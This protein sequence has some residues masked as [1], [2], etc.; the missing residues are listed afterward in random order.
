MSNNNSNVFHCFQISGRLPRSRKTPS[1][2]ASTL[3]PTRMLPESRSGLGIK[4]KLSLKTRQ[5]QMPTATDSISPSMLNC[6]TV[7]CPSTRMR[8]KNG[9]STSKHIMNTAVWCAPQAMPIQAT[10]TSFSLEYEIVTQPELVLMIHSQYSN[11]L[12]ILY[13]WVL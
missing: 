6:L 3:W 4:T 7:T 11:C 12:A 2:K 13:N 9:P 1:T 10:L 5:L 8:W